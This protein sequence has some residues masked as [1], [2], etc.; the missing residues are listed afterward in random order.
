MMR[1]WG[2]VLYTPIDLNKSKRANNEHFRNMEYKKV[3]T[4]KEKMKQ[5]KRK[6]TKLSIDKWGMINERK[7]ITYNILDYRWLAH[8]KSTMFI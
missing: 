4:N 5:Q 2:R 1:L 6:P 8:V 3:K 7:I